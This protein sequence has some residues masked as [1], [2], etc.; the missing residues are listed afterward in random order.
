MQIIFKG[1]MVLCLPEHTKGSHHSWL[2]SHSGEQPQFLCVI[3][4]VFWFETSIFHSFMFLIFVVSEWW[5]MICIYRKWNYHDKK[6]SK[7]VFLLSFLC[8]N[9]LPNLL[10]SRTRVS[11]LWTTGQICPIYFCNLGAKNIY[12]I[13]N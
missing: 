1:L 7:S 11:K 13:P 8:I 4:L 9:D 3:Q 12:H 10:S 5:R 6:L 2:G